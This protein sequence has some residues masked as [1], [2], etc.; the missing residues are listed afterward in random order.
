MKSIALWLL[1]AG[2]VA[3]QQTDYCM[4]ERCNIAHTMCQFNMS[5]ASK[6][7]GPVEER[8]VTTDDQSVIVSYHNKIRADVAS[9]MYQS[10]GLPA[11]KSLPPLQWDSELATIAQRLA[12]QCGQYNSNLSFWT[13]NDVDRFAVGQ[14]AVEV[15][16]GVKNWTFVVYDV[17]FMNELNR[18]HQSNLMF[19]SKRDA[20]MGGISQLIQ[21]LWADT[22]EVGCGYIRARTP[23]V[24]EENQPA[25]NGPK[26]FYVCLYGPYGPEDN[27]PGQ[28][29]Y[30]EARV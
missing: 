19:I 18:F 20:A 15:W 21:L 25:N 28:Y 24:E 2:A 13:C 16:S 29:I 12:D 27:I 5:G 1:L 4:V 11:A 17:F 10:R 22:T 3:A 23:V 26:Q 8:G 30:E 14:N 7:C 6:G 9:G